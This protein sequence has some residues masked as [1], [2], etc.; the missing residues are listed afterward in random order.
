MRLSQL[1][2]G[3]GFDAVF[4]AWISLLK[5][6]RRFIAVSPFAGLFT[7]KDDRRRQMVASSHVP[8]TSV[9]VI[10]RIAAMAFAAASFGAAWLR[11]DTGSDCVAGALAGYAT[12]L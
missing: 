3:G 11:V 5:A 6:C 12:T 8:Q 1:R 9:A 4:F 10:P 7:N 2:R